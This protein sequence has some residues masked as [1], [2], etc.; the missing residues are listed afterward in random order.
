[1]GVNILK[2]TIFTVINKFTTAITLVVETFFLPHQH[3]IIAYISLLSVIN[4]VQDS[5]FLQKKK[6]NVRIEDIIRLF[7]FLD[8]KFYKLLK[9]ISKI[10]VTFYI[11]EWNFK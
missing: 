9:I 8:K 7:V 5:S 3:C 6:N 4:P 2:L 10:R 1:M 11:E